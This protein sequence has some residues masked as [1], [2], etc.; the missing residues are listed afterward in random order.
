MFVQWFGCRTKRCASMK[1][2]VL[3]FQVTQQV[4]SAPDDKT[5]CRHSNRLQDVSD[6]MHDR[7]PQVLVFM[8]MRVPMRV[9]VVR[10]VV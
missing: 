5:S 10:M 4:I 1:R 9:A 8:I 7:P 6:D 2:A 3:S